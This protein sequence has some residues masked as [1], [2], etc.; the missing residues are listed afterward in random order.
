[1][2]MSPQPLTGVRPVGSETADLPRLERHGEATRLIVDGKPYLAIGGEL[3]NSTSSDPAYL[4]Q[5]CRALRDT[6]VTTIVATASWAEIEPREGEFDFES[7]SSVLSIARES[8]LRVVLIWFGAFKNARST[9]AP[10]WVRA[11]RHRFPRAEVLPDEMSSR[12][13]YPGAMPKPALSVFSPQLRDADASAYLALLHHL[14]REDP[15]H[16]VI[17]VQIENEVGLLGGGRDRSPLAAA[18]WNERV[19]REVVDAVVSH[20]EFAGTPLHVEGGPTDGTWQEV[21]GDNNQSDELFMSWGFASYVEQ[22]AS[23]GKKVL[24]LPTLVNAWLGPQPGQTLAGQYPSGGPTAGM[25]PVWEA[26]APSIDIIAPDIYVQDSESVMRDYSRG[27]RTLFIPEARFRVADL[28]LAIA[29]YNAIGYCAF[30]VEEGRPGNQ[31]FTASTLLVSQSDAIAAAQA[32]G[33]IRAVLVDGTGP[34]V[35]ELGGYSLTVHDT[36]QLYSRILLDAGVAAPQ[37]APEPELESFTGIFG[38]DKAEARPFGAVLQLADD[39]FLLVGMGYTVDFAHPS[40]EVELDRVQELRPEA[41]TWIEGRVLNGDE[42]M[43]LIPA[44]S[45]GASRVRLLRHP[46]R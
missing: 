18:A 13:S 26:L 43:S 35:L 11:D 2:T 40:Y 6:G 45:I 46:S 15:D 7:V 22:L 31:Y 4:A 5:V 37:A 1:M 8:G 33:L 41:G 20:P 44:D 29:R 16:T 28:F 3:H 38:P 32:A 21:F 17:M 9:Y 24:A 14:K 34:Q 12:F 42:H 27:G 10:T 30:G 36:R 39:E 19:P 25:I 23:E